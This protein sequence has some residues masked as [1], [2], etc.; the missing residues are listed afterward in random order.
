MKNKIADYKLF[1]LF[2]IYRKPNLFFFSIYFF[3][4]FFVNFVFLNTNNLIIVDAVEAVFENDLIEEKNIVLQDV[5]IDTLNLY[6]KEKQWPLILKF[7]PQGILD[8]FEEAAKSL[9]TLKPGEQNIILYPKYLANLDPDELKEHLML[10]AYK[11]DKYKGKEKELIIGYFVVK[12]I[13]EHFNDPNFVTQFI[14]DPTMFNLDQ[15]L[16]NQIFQDV[17]LDSI[18]QFLFTFNSDLPDLNKVTPELA[19]LVKERLQDNIPIFSIVIEYII[20][21]NYESFLENSNL[22]TALEIENLKLVFENFKNFEKESL[23]NNIFTNVVENV[24][25][26]LPHVFRNKDLIECG[27]QYLNVVE[28]VNIPFQNI[29][30]DNHRNVFIKISNDFFISLNDYIAPG[31]WFFNKSEGFISIPIYGEDL[32]SVYANLLTNHQMDS[33]LIE[34]NFND[35]IIT[36]AN[37]NN[38]LLKHDIWAHI[39]SGIDEV[40]TY[41]DFVK[42]SIDDFRLEVNTQY[43]DWE[44][45]YKDI[46]RQ[47][48]LLQGENWYLGIDLKLEASGLDNKWKQ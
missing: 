26:H 19:S 22:N 30:I 34:Y 9:Q 37:P 42:E 6:V 27:S 45:D 47:L 7:M 24:N 14:M 32:R 5:S 1:F 40:K 12:I 41:Q 8:G 35:N 21:T 18:N 17:D 29:Y 16:I 33:Y 11:L 15:N 36:I 44:R 2:L 39:Q 4:L 28:N 46:R 31:T 10:E 23:S 20:K 48:M 13:M 38:Y 25:M 43:E 3:F